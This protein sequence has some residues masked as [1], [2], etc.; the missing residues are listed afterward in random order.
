MRE[1]IVCHELNPKGGEH[2][3]EGGFL[4]VAIGLHGTVSVPTA[5][6]FRMSLWPRE[7]LPADHLRVRLEQSQSIAMPISGECRPAQIG[8]RAIE[9]GVPREQ[10]VRRAHERIEDVVADSG[11]RPE[12]DG[13]TRADLLRSWAAHVSEVF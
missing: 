3:E 9:L 13:I 8:K 2:I 7:Q 10:L 12:A 1:P 6:G 11:D 5:T 4:I